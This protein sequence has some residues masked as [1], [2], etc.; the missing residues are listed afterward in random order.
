V[1][2]QTASRASPRLA[3]ALRGALGGSGDAER[4]VVIDVEGA[5]DHLPQVTIGV[6]EVT[7]VAAWRA[8][9]TGHG[10][11]EEQWNGASAIVDPDG[12]GPRIYLQRCL[13]AVGMKQ[14]PPK[15]PGFC[16]SRLTKINYRAGS[17]VRR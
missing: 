14:Q 6:S 10:I 4:S 2:D 13:R 9:L 12:D 1:P 5:P 17:G 3:R 8:W 7:F 11:P 15:L 16:E